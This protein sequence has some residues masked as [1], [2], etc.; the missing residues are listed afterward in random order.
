MRA[1]QKALLLAVAI[2][3]ALVSVAVLLGAG[4]LVTLIW[5]MA[6]TPFI[7]MTAVYKTLG[8]LR[9]LWLVLLLIGWGL[10]GALYLYV[11]CLLPLGWA[12]LPAYVWIVPVVPAALGLVLGFWEASHE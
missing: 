8:Q 1:I 7:A 9:P 10:L 3:A 5:V 2:V 12:P 6:L 4:L 11:S